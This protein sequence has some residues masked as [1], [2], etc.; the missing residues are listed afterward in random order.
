MAKLKH[1]RLMHLINDGDYQLLQS[2]KEGSPIP[3][4]KNDDQ[5][6]EIAIKQHNE[7]F[8]AEKKEKEFKENVEWD[9]IGTKLKPIIRSPLKTGGPSK[10]NTIPDMVDEVI[11]VLQPNFQKK[12]RQ[13]LEGL[14][15]EDGISIDKKSIYVN[16]NLVSG[17]LSDIID[18]LVRP[19]KRLRMNLDGLLEY[20][21]NINFPISLVKNLEA[22]GK[23]SRGNDSTL[24][25]SDN[26]SVKPKA[27]STPR[28]GGRRRNNNNS[29]SDQSLHEEN[30]RET[31]GDGM[32]AYFSAGHSGQSGMGWF[33]F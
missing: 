22:L 6:D 24:N 2:Y 11:Q 9:K 31:T 13:L 29:K 25:A 10:T 4:V 27:Y 30:E 21:K 15:S 12:G 5:P 3:L 23:L 33:S 1:G 17:N 20:M 19:R 8:L 14:L 7:K 18:E 16:D 26:I 28:R 32:S